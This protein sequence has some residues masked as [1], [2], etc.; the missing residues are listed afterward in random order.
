[1]IA[2][3]EG[4]EALLIEQV[5]LL[6]ASAHQLH[7][8]GTSIDGSVGV[9]CWDDLQARSNSVLSH[10]CSSILQSKCCRVHFV[11][12]QEFLMQ[13]I[14]SHHY[15]CKPKL[16]SRCIYFSSRQFTI[17]KDMGDVNL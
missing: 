17:A 14:I 4:V 13:S 5:E 15:G 12:M 10:E 16:G 8:E 1:L 9:K 6:Q 7:G 11:L 3:L 2:H